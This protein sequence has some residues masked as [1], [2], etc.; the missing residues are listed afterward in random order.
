MNREIHEI[1]EPRKLSG[2]ED[3]MMA[4]KELK[5]RKG[6]RMQFYS[7]NCNPSESR[8]GARIFSCKRQRTREKA[9]ARR[10]RRWTQMKNSYS[11]SAII[12]VICG[13]VRIRLRLAA[14][15]SLC[16]FAAKYALFPLK[17]ALF[18]GKLMDAFEVRQ[19]VKLCV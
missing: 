7:L 16:S 11:V 8:I 9:F 17:S 3:C 10:T 6:F 5:E 13:Q 15:C 4:A 1:R 12:G 19:E 2:E 18:C 14:L